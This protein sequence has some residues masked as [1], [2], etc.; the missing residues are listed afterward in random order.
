MLVG[1]YLHL[2]DNTSRELRILVNCGSGIRINRCVTRRTNNKIST[3]IPGRSRGVRPAR[4][5]VS[6]ETGLVS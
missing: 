6:G 3:D 2:H 5:K 4:L 1:T